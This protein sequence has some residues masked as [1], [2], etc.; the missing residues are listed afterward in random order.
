MQCSHLAEVNAKDMTLHLLD[1]FVPRGLD[2]QRDYM[3]DFISGHYLWFKTISETY[4]KC[5]GIDAVVYA[6]KLSEPGYPW[7]LLA[8][9]LFSRMWRLHCC[10]LF[11]DYLF[12]SRED[13]DA[14]QCQIRLMCIGDN[15]F[16]LVDDLRSDRSWNNLIIRTAVRNIDAENNRASNNDGSDS[17]SSHSPADNTD[18]D[19]DF[20]IGAVE[21]STNDSSERDLSLS[22]LSSVDS[23]RHQDE[24][25]ASSQQSGDETEEIDYGDNLHETGT[26]GNVLSHADEVETEKNDGQTDVISEE[27]FAADVVTNPVDKNTSTIVKEDVPETKETEAA[28]GGTK[29]KNAETKLTAPVDAGTQGTEH[30]HERKETEAA[31]GGTKGKNAETN[32]TA[33]VDAGTQGTEHVHE[34]KET[35]AAD[36]GTK[37]K[38]AETNVTAPVDGGTKGKKSVPETNVTA[39]VDGGTKGKKPVS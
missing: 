37:G 2:A 23:E 35:E 18:E 30:V 22:D 9:V 33:P 4:L 5:L 11:E 15:K 25:Y 12:I 39:P 28:D 1:H 32:V 27:A 36:G 13:E 8:I 7:D 20:D 10:V 14:E 38:N 21:Y 3:R 16:C 19:A 26:N 24:G 6:K 31:D 34:S 29:G 17:E